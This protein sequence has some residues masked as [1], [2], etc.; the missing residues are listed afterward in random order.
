MV[1]SELPA[2]SKAASSA[3]AFCSAGQCVPRLI[4]TNN[5]SPTPA[6]CVGG[7]PPIVVD[8]GTGNEC[9]GNI[10]ATGRRVIRLQMNLNRPGDDWITI[11][12][13]RRRT[14]RDGRFRYGFDYGAVSEVSEGKWTVE[15]DTVLLTTDPMPPKSECDRGFASA[16]FDRTPLGREGG[17][18]I[19]WR[20]DAKIRLKPVQP[21]PR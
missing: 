19:L 8:D 7:G 14:Q 2:V 3:G 16:C 12:G 6:R 17:N 4:P 9:T 5:F 13:F 10:G 1:T 21:R 15:G 20:W 11:D 18:L